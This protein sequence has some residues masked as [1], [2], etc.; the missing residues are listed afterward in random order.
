MINSFHALQQIVKL[1]VMALL[2][3]HD[4]IHTDIENSKFFIWH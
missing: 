2:Y 4:N 1:H 3:L